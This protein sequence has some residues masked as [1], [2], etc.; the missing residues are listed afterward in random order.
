M[1]ELTIRE[2]KDERAELQDAVEKCL[3]KFEKETGVAVDYLGVS[4]AEH[5]CATGE[6]AVVY[7][8]NAGVVI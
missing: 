5:T 2:L 3:V 7:Q 6:R 1:S 4:R 8:V